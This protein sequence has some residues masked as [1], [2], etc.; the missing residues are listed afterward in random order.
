M[1]RHKTIGFTLVELLVV[2]GIITLLISLLLPAVARAREHALRTKCAANLRSL[3]Q[4]LTLY[5]QRYSSYPGFSVSLGGSRAYVVWPTR[6]RAFL[7]GEQRA[8]HCPARP[9]E[10]EWRDARGSVAVAG[11]L[12]RFPLTGYGYEEGEPLLKPL[13]VR[14][15]YAYNM[16]GDG[17]RAS[18]EIERQRGLGGIVG[19][20]GLVVPGYRELP[21]S[22]VRVSSEMIAITDSKGDGIADFGVMPSRG[23]PYTLPGTVHGGG[24]NV[25]FCD[26]HVRWYLQDEL[27]VGAEKGK[28]PRPG[29]EVR[30]R[31]WNNDN[32]P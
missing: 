26:G 9:S 21:A 23:S 11:E 18:N 28:E 2:I 20:R 17:S 10:F 3:G 29:D 8:F 22:R 25:L 30:R 12:A 6:L 31:M 27:L 7:S 5:T 14:F 4:A 13:G 24:S 32:Q 19:I 15:S 16:W 1:R